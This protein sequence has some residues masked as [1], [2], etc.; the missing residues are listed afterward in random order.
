M[1]ITNCNLLVL[2]TLVL[3]SLAAH[4][5]DKIIWQHQYDYVAI[6]TASQINGE[7]TSNI[8]TQ[9]MVLHALTTLKY[10]ENNDSIFSLS[11]NSNPV[12]VFSHDTANALASKVF[13]GLSQLSANEVVV[14]SI[15]EKTPGYLGIDSKTVTTT[16]TVFVTNNSLNIL[17]GALQVNIVKRYIKA[18]NAIQNGRVPT[19]AELAHFR[20]ATGAPDETPNDNWQLVNE[21]PSFVLKRSNWIYVNSQR[22]TTPLS[23]ASTP[24]YAATPQT[25]EEIEEP[26]AANDNPTATV[27]DRLQRLKSLFD[28]GYLPKALYEDKVKQILDEI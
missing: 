18:G 9:P 25:F 19:A 16:G 4:A 14:F 1:K 6:K 26:R 12:S 17:I 5:Q 23:V 8:I 27:E 15:S 11:R 2:L 3:F 24:T 22:N 10:K 20:L 7:A 28:S 21:D 13:Q